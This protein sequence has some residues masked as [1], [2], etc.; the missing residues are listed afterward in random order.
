MSKISEILPN[1]DYKIFRLDRSHLTHPPHAADPKKFRRNGGGVLIAITNSFDLN[2]KLFVSKAK[3][4][5]LS[6]FDTQKF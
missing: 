2:P 4:E 6:Y 1:K 5:I 3:A